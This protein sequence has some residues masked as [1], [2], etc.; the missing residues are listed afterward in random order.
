MYDVKWKIRQ[1]TSKNDWGSS[2][3]VDCDMEVAENIC[4]EEDDLEWLE[5]AFATEYSEEELVGMTDNTI[6]DVLNEIEY[7]KLDEDGMH[8]GCTPCDVNKFWNSEIAKSVLKNRYG[9]KFN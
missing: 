6:E 1:W 4:T 2:G 8:V 9:Y 3:Y 7:Y 5:E